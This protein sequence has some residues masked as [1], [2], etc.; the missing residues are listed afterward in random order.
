MS[1]HANITDEALARLKSQRRNSSIAAVLV[2]TLIM[3]LLGLLFW[4]IGIAIFSDE[5][6]PMVTF[7]EEVA[8]VDEVVQ[9]KITTDVKKT[10]T[11]PSSSAVNIVVAQSQ[12]SF[13]IP[14]P[15]VTVDSLST[16]FGE[17]E[18]FGNGW[19]GG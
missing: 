19:G 16:E 17:S 5:V 7:H 2:G 15:D 11:S 6:E 9:E 13:S 8:E 18:G 10:P 4:M 3:M 1:L 14:T 12:S